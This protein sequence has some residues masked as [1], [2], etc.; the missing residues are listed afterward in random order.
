[1]VVSGSKGTSNGI[2]SEHT[3][4]SPLSADLRKSRDGS[5]P[6]RNREGDFNMLVITVIISG[7]RVEKVNEKNYSNVLSVKT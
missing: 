6:S 4:D 5:Y 3:G 7:W 1:M 2:T